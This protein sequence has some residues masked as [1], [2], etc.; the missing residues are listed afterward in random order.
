MRFP[1]TGRRPDWQ[2]RGAATELGAAPPARWPCV[3]ASRFSSP[4]ASE[5]SGG[6]GGGGGGG[7][8]PEAGT[9]VAPPPP[10][11]FLSPPRPP[12]P[13]R[14]PGRPGFRIKIVRKS[15]K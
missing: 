5:A 15:G 1:D 13:P 6:G 12:L 14:N 3:K 8:R 10:S 4:P 2:A 7:A 9:S 11:A